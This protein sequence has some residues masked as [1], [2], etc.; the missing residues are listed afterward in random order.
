M[1]F[2]IFNTL[3]LLLLLG[4]LTLP[5]VSAGIL[6]FGDNREVLSAQSVRLK[7]DPKT[8]LNKKTIKEVQQ[9]IPEENSQNM[10]ARY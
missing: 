6:S 10:D 8:I 7:I 4:I 3:L 1:G 2:F 9:D 5:A